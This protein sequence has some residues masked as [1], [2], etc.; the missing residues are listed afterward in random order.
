[1]STA[2]RVTGRTV[3]GEGGAVP[4]DTTPRDDDRLTTEGPAGGQ[5]GEATPDPEEAS[6]E[7]M[8]LLEQHVPLAL[9]AD[10]TN[11]E[12]PGSPTIL[13][14]EGLPDVSWLEGDDDASSGTTP[15]R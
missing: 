7:V 9:L 2:V 6:A 3:Q 5:P 1:M 11:P 13:E 10:L 14:D 4:V 8:H 15:A 12:G